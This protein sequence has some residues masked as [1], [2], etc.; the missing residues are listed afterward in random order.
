MD[1]KFKHT[2]SGDKLT[3]EMNT[4]K[5]TQDLVS[6]LSSAYPY[7][8]IA[9]YKTIE[10]NLEQVKMIDS[11]SLG[12]LFELHNKIKAENEDGSLILSVGSNHELKD[13]LH[14]F[15]VDLL[16]NVQ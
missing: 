6:N 2:V 12:Y 15:Q 16:L 7:S 8:A 3:I 10:F 4:H 11:S 14:R 1:D 9:T 5:F 13:L